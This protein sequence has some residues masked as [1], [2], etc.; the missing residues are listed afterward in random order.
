MLGLRVM[1]IFSV[2]TA[3][4]ENKAKSEKKSVISSWKLILFYHFQN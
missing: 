3:G 1:L 4:K 2:K